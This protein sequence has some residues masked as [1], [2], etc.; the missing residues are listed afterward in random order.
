MRL[1]RS[2]LLPQAGRMR[3]VP[4]ARLASRW[5]LCQRN[6]YR[7][8]GPP[9]PAKTPAIRERIVGGNR[10]LPGSG[11]FPRAQTTS[12]L[13]CTHRRSGHC[14]RRSSS[15][16][17]RKSAV[18]LRVCEY[19]EPD[20]CC[21]VVAGAVKSSRCLGPR[22]CFR[23]TWRRPRP[24]AGTPG[25]ARVVVDMTKSNAAQYKEHKHALSISLC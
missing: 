10:L 11:C 2:D 7:R 22:W 9:V 24:S 13:P 15:S 1:L 23:S 5:C 3:A 6:D 17:R 20:S 16:G 14:L 21:R 4:R 19:R 8:C 12:S 25:D 18:A